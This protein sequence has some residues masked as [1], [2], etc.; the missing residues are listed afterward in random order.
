M[1]EQAKK[2][3]YP[4]RSPNR[5]ANERFVHLRNC[6]NDY[7]NGRM[8]NNVTAFIRT[9][10]GVDYVSFAEC[11]SRD[12]FCRQR[13]RVVA[14]RKWFRDKRVPLTTEGIVNNMVNEK[15]SLYDRCLDTYY[16]TTGGGR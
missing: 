5:E 2:A 7:P 3:V 8:V 14:R 9:K 15:S 6:N 13:G 12:Q 1:K 4:T 10:D 16:D 11:D